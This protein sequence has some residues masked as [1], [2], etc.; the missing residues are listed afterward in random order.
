MEGRTTAVIIVFHCV[1]SS[2]PF[3]SA[4][5]DYPVSGCRSNNSSIN[6][7]TEPHTDENSP[8]S[9]GSRALCVTSSSCSAPSTNPAF[10]AFW[11]RCTC[12][13]TQLA[14]S[15]GSHSRAKKQPASSSASDDDD[16]CST[17][18]T[19]QRGAARRQKS[20]GSPVLQRLDPS[21]A[22]AASALPAVPASFEALSFVLGVLGVLGVLS[23]L[24]ALGA[25]GV[26]SALS[27][28]GALSTLGALSALSA[29]DVL[30]TQDCV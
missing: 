4:A 29:L 25:L 19:G 5:N 13:H 26:L 11:H 24:G 18:S 22:S 28:L 17:S 16:C 1:S 10:S 9:V 3:S 6:G 21:L 20:W 23:A 27:A 14:R 8:F 12:S 7:I 30:G 15:A 2:L